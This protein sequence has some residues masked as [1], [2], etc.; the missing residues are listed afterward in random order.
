MIEDSIIRHK[1]DFCEWEGLPAFFKTSKEADI[2]FDI[3]AA[4]FYL[5]SRYEEYLLYDP[6]KH[7][8]F[9]SEQSIATEGGFLEDPIVDQWAY[10]LVDKIKEKFPSFEINPKGFEFVP[11]FDIDNAYAYKNKGVYRAILGTLKSLITLNYSD[12]KDRF[13]VYFKVKKDP[14]D[15][16]D[17]VFSILDEWPNTI[18]FALVGKYGRYDRNVS[19]QNPEM[20]NLLVRIRNRFNVGIHPSYYSGTN[21]DRV[22]GEVSNIVWAIDKEVMSSRQHYLRLFFPTTYSNLIS[23]GIKE[24]YSM[25]YSNHSGFRAGTCTPILFLQP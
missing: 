16:Y 22:R 19:I 23:L 10:K 11:T 25:G 12:V 14:Y 21:I 4:S 8:R 6:D 3:F 5:V 13:S 20:R 1:I 7:N 2:Q 18:W 24:D 9:T 17:R 15:I